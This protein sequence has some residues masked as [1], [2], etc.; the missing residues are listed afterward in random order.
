MEP[1][2]DIAKNYVRFAPV[3][4]IATVR[5]NGEPHVI[6]VCPALTANRRC[7]WTLGGSILARRAL[8]RAA[9]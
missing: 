7:M 5:T 8:L 4:R 3:C 2:P 1:L 9:R 6:P